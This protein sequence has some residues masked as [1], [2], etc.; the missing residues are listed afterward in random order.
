MTTWCSCVKITRTDSAVVGITDHDVNLTISGTTYSSA[1][2][3]TPTAWS[4]SAD[5]AVDTADVQGI[6]DAAGVDREDIRAGL[7]D[8]AAVEWFLYDYVSET[9]LKILATG[10]WGGVTLFENRYVAEVRNLSQYLQETIGEVT[11][12]TCRA[13]L[14]DSRCTVNLATLQETLTLTGVTDERTFTDT[15]RTEADNYWR[16]GKVTFTSG[17]NNGFSME[18]KSS[19]SAGLFTLFQDLPYVPAVSDTATVIP[20][21]DKTPT[22][23]KNVFSNFVNYQG[24]PHLPGQRKALKFA[25]G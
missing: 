7:Y 12:P 5:L 24:E 11:T 1:A 8:R 15:A 9:V 18:I 22:T 3:Y 20:G 13:D 21:C 6:L 25:G 4:G 10:T 14:G 17:V 19:T 2:G 16:G 23:C